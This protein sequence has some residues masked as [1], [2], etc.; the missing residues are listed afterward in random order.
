MKRRLIVSILLLIALSACGST[1]G[2]LADD[3][4]TGTIP[5]VSSIAPTTG[6]VGTVITINGLGFSDS[7]PNNIV[8]IG[9][10]A[11]SA[12]TYSLVASPTP[13]EIESLTATIPAGTTVGSNSI[14]VVVHENTSNSDISFTVTP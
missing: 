7:P 10:T 4:P 1:G 9:N 5:I 2:G 13:T 8:I 3:V 11:V 6:P 12:A 14:V